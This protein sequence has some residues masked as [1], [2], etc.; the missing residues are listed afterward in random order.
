MYKGCISS[1]LLVY[2][3]F[4]IYTT[5]SLFTNSVYTISINR[6]AFLAMNLDNMP[7]VPLHLKCA[8]S[9]RLLREAVELP[10]C[11][12]V[13]TYSIYDNSSNRL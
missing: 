11:H 8:R 1:I 12:R 13:S 2:L 4:T 5:S 3:L 7:D 6:E 10:C 9:N